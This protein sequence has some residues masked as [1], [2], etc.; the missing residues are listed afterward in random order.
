MLL[1]Q[2]HVKYRVA[3]SG[4]EDHMCYVL[5]RRASTE[6]QRMQAVRYMQSHICMLR[7]AHSLHVQQKEYLLAYDT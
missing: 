7:H 1:A 3:D 2:V 4:Q 5:L 6:G